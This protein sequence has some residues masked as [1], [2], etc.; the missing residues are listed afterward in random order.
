MQLVPVEKWLLSV[1]LLEYIVLEKD[2]LIM[3]R[4]AHFFSIH[5]RGGV[6]GRLGGGVAV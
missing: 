2:S 6:G 3:Y 1:V 5:S 4:F